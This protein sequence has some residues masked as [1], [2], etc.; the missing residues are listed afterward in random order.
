MS[1]NHKI[2]LFLVVVFLC[3]AS[4]ANA[5]PACFVSIPQEEFW[6]RFWGMAFMGIIPLVVAAFVMIKISRMIKNESKQS[7]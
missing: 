6:K 7:A 4:S 1:G 2:T 3:G 5:C